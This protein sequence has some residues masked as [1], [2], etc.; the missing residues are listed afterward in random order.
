MSSIL[1]NLSFL[2]LRPFFLDRWNR[3]IEPEL[4]AF[5]IHI[6]V[7]AVIQDAVG[8]PIFGRSGLL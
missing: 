7:E 8:A 3:Q 5:E 4:V 6:E 1:H 2:R